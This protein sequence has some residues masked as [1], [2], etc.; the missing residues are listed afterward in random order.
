MVMS[1]VEGKKKVL[2]S[3][4][5][6]AH[7]QLG[8]FR[9]R[10]PFSLKKKLNLINSKITSIENRIKKMKNF[11]VVPQIPSSLNNKSSPLSG[12]NRTNKEQFQQLLK[13]I[14]NNNSLRKQQSVKLD[15]ED[16]SDTTFTIV[17]DGSIIESQLLQHPIAHHHLLNLL[18]LTI[19]PQT[20]I[21]EQKLKR[22]ASYVQYLDNNYNEE[23]VQTLLRDN[24]LL[25]TVTSPM[26]IDSHA[27][28][29]GLPFAMPPII[30]NSSVFKFTAKPDFSSL[31]C[32]MTL[33]IKP[34][35]VANNILNDTTYNLLKESLS[36]VYCTA[37][38][39]DTTKRIFSFCTNGRFSWM[40]YMIRKHTTTTETTESHMHETYYILPITI[41][42]IFQLWH[43]ITS[44]STSNPLYYCISHAFLISNVLYEHGIDIAYCS[45][46]KL[47]HCMS[48]VYG[49]GLYYT[50]SH[51]KL[52]V[53]NDRSKCFLMLKIVDH[54]CNEAKILNY[55]HH[56]DCKAVEY[57]ISTTF[58]D[59]KNTTDPFPI[60][61]QH[62][63]FYPRTI[64]N[65][66]Y[67]KHPFTIKTSI[68][69]SPT[70]INGKQYSKN[71]SPNFISYKDAVCWWNFSLKS[72]NV[73]SSA[74]VGNPYDLTTVYQ[75]LED[76]CCCIL[77]FP[78]DVEAPI[79]RKDIFHCLEQIHEQ[80]VLHCDLRRP[81]L[82]HFPIMTNEI[83]PTGK[84]YIVDFQE[85]YILKEGEISKKVR[86]K[87]GD[88]RKR[89]LQDL[90]EVD[91]AI[92]FYEFDKGTERNF[93][94][95]SSLQQLDTSGKWK[96]T[97]ANDNLFDDDV[98]NE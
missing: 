4:S 27:T 92:L 64:I 74:A 44:K 6:K 84:S 11:S 38:L 24:W 30:N 68:A 81:N 51:G 49:I 37:N 53:C 94:I 8:A 75:A 41:K 34:H 25:D 91:P 55:L 20:T 62:T 70:M 36:R 3:L 95:F 63:N 43:F 12:D 35:T 13:S 7:P 23:E 40:V 28:N 31:V 59:K 79:V 87:E 39:N 33:E 61:M 93:L 2:P 88:D 17:T 73:S 89:L 42:S 50:D 80:N 52:C 26:A 9:L 69:F 85:G 21:S 29:H 65:D 96:K 22:L 98:R 67:A 16:I 86:L 97:E 66:L 58:H 77:M 76:S 57:V 18:H 90:F 48:V 60:T 1:E 82:L 45:I 83:N 78:G 46:K 47:I 72:S 10:K 71:V 14:V 19:P 15:L 56:Q 5:R 32:P 54:S